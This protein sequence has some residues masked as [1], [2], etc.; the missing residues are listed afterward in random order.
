M[1]GHVPVGTGQQT[2]IGMHPYHHQPQQQVIVVTTTP[3]GQPARQVPSNVRSVVETRTHYQPQPRPVVTV[4][5][6]HQADRD[7]RQIPGTNAVV[8]TFRRTHQ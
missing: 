6:Q 7:V 3:S 1:S 4:V 2:P 5:A 8:G